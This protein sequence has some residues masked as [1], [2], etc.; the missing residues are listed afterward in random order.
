VNSTVVRIALVVLC[1][2]TIG[3]TATVAQKNK[4]TSS[5]WPCTLTFH[6]GVDD[7]AITSDGRP[8]VNGKDGV[9]CVVVPPGS[10]AL[11][12]GDLSLYF[13]NNT[14]RFIN[15]AGRDSYTDE[16]GTH[17]GFSAFRDKGS[18]RV[19]LLAFDDLTMGGPGRAF[20]AYTNVGRFLASTD[21]PDFSG[22]ELVTIQQD[23][24]CTWT[25]TFDPTGQPPSG[26]ARME[27]W[28]GPHWDKY[29]GTYQMPFA[30]TVVVT[31][32]KSGCGG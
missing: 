22:E 15:Y 18:F 21:D 19:K 13:A 30:L 26:Q 7:A 28:Q 5:N 3:T 9:T 14:R 25:V 27:L 11:T 2:A 1:A 20:I 4:T 10:G 17:S 32:G 23:G 31:G 8:Y 6:D 24:A 16:N 29:A 12:E